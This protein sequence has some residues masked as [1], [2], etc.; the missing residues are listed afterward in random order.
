M[1]SEAPDDEVRDAF[2][3]NNSRLTSFGRST[4]LT[5]Q[6]GTQYMHRFD[7]LLFMPQITAVWNICKII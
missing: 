1:V 7:R 5:F 2:D 3:N 4:E 6:A